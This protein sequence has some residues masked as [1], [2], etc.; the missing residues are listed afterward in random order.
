MLNIGY[1][2]SSMNIL[3]IFVLANIYFDKKKY[4]VFFYITLFMLFLIII[5]N[6]G[7]ILNFL[8]SESSQVLY[9][10]FDFS[11]NFFGKHGPRSTG[12][13]RTFLLIMII[14]NL[15]FYQFLNE[16]LYLKYIIYIS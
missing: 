9:L 2:I 5:L 6:Y 15:V 3:F 8:I 1:V 4:I 16:R 12:S 10:Y 7:T 11:E 14:L 13:S